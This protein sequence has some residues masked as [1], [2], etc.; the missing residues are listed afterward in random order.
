MV[1]KLFIIFCVFYST[2]CLCGDPPHSVEERMAD[3]ALRNQTTNKSSNPNDKL[4]LLR[5]NGKVYY[6][7]DKSALE[8]LVN[9][10][11][12]DPCLRR[13][14]GGGIKDL[15]NRLMESCHAN[16]NNL[17]AKV[18]SLGGEPVVMGTR[19]SG[20]VQYG[21]HWLSNKLGI[22]QYDQYVECLVDSELL[23]QQINTLKQTNYYMPITADIDACIKSINIAKDDPNTQS[24]GL[25]PTVTN[26]DDISNITQLNQSYK[27]KT[28][29]FNVKVNANTNKVMVFNGKVLVACNNNKAD[30]IIKPVY[31]GIEDCQKQKYNGIPQS[32]PV[33]DGLYIVRKDDMSLG[34]N[35][36]GGE[37][38]WGKYAFPLIPA[39]T[40]NTFGRGSMYL[41]GTSDPNK[42]RSAG[43]ISLGLKVGEFVD[44][45]WINGDVPIIVRMSN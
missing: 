45:N 20:A 17:V 42:H 34:Q 31:S 4:I 10:E 28:F 11:Q 38:S 21:K 13:L 26:E 32:G 2:A 39:K 3:R 1:K 40:T 23:S 44:T 27:D 15:W 33:P 14:F 25:T 30:Y 29:T 35:R 9:K 16:R 43:C 41:H 22:S 37:K 24:C 36:A 7:K 6:V 19:G 12:T 8:A 5:V 18:E